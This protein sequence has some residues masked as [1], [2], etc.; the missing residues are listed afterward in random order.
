L[1]PAPVTDDSKSYDAP[2]NGVENT[3]DSLNSR[4]EVIME[5][6]KGPIDFS[7][8]MDDMMTST[9]QSSTSSRDISEGKSQRLNPSASAFVPA[10]QSG[11]LMPPPPVPQ[12]AV[13]LKKTKGKRPL[14]TVPAQEKPKKRHTD[15]ES[16]ALPLNTPPPEA[17]EQE[18][19]HRIAKREKAISVVKE[20]PE[21]LAYLAARPRHERLP[22]DPQTPTA[23]DRNLSKRRWEYEIQQWRSQLKLWSPD[24]VVDEDSNA[25]VILTD[26]AISD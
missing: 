7:F 2:A 1:P 22:A 11:S 15:Q 17:S 4:L 3:K 24:G 8:L 14:S 25:D 20:F 5:M 23:Q 21:Y 18:W 16:K 26:E 19:Q 6:K 10:A 12:E 13:K 9:S